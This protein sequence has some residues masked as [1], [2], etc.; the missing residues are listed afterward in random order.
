MCLLVW[1]SSIESDLP[2]TNLCISGTA[3]HL[4][5]FLC[6]LALTFIN[7][8]SSSLVYQSGLHGLS[9]PLSLFTVSYAGQHHREF[10]IIHRMKTFSLC[11]AHVDP[12]A[13][14]LRPHKSA[15]SLFPRYCTVVSLHPMFVSG[16]NI[17]RTGSIFPMMMS[18]STSE[19]L[20]EEDKGKEALPLV[21]EK[22]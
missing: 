8:Q 21:S 18:A 20:L 4:I 10:N 16:G 22:Q 12:C 15:K 13:C 1:A 9:W 6:S 3:S 7:R 2:R 19:G 11:S 17:F 14:W 5:G